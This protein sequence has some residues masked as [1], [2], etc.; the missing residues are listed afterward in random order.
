MKKM[1]SVLLGFLLICSVSFAKVAVDTGPVKEKCSVVCAQADT[2]VVCGFEMNVSFEATS[3]ETMDES[4]YAFESVPDLQIVKI[5]YLQLKPP[6]RLFIDFGEKLSVCNLNLKNE[7]DPMILDHI[8][9]GLC[10]KF[11]I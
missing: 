1:F 4:F 3:F 7:N 8:D 2:A 11:E 6:S 5:D 9:P 10:Q